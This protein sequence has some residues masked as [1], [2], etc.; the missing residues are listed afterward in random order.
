MAIL[1][2]L[3]YMLR[4]MVGVRSAIWNEVLRLLLTHCRWIVYGD[5]NMVES[6]L[7]RSTLSY[8]WLLGLKEELMWFDIRNKFDVEDYF[9]RRG[10][11]IYSWTNFQDDGMWMLARLDRF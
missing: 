1:G 7:D 4:N 5:F 9:S 11:P 3:M 10:G 8:S 6:P 2:F